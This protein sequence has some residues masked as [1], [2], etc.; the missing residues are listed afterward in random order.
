V[1]VLEWRILKRDMCESEELE[2]DDNYV[3]FLRLS[4][5]MENPAS[6]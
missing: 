4:N 2:G 1:R 6:G 5:E 3:L